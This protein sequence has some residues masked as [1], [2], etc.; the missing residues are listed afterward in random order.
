[1]G[2]GFTSEE[3][4][5]VNSEVFET[6]YFASM[7]ASKDLAKQHGAYETF[8]G[9]P[10]SE[11]QFQF[12]LWDV[13][14]EELSGR[15]DWG[16]L[17]EKM[18][19]YGTRNSLLTTI[20]PTAST[21]Q[22]MNNNESIEPFASNIYVRKTLAGDYIIVNKYLINDLKKI[23]KWN[24]DIYQEIIYDNGSIQNLDIDSSIKEKYKTAYE[25]KQ[26]V[27][28]K[29]SVDRSLFIDQSQSLNIF[30]SKPDFRLLHTCHMYS[31]KNGLKTGMY[32][33]RSQPATEGIKFGIDSEVIK[34]I[35]NKRNIEYLNRDNN[36]N[37][38]EM[39]SA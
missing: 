26:S 12:N 34:T 15:W 18:M 20:M 36:E 8:K 25:L 31:W 4:R 2:I 5:K 14:D 10:L 32:Y 7:T 39:C 17:R 30:M 38:C 35:K 29:Q 3:A 24:N 6:I 37:T 33:L 16:A 22:I 21:A 9:S 27:L 13:K 28:L 11:G 23:N 1:M 19:L